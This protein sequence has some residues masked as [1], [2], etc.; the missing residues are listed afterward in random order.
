MRM[1]LKCSQVVADCVIL[2]L[3]EPARS[4]S[5]FPQAFSNRTSSE[6]T[7]HYVGSTMRHG[8]CS[9]L[10]PCSMRAQGILALRS[11][12]SLA[13]ACAQT[14]S[15]HLAWGN[16]A[17]AVAQACGHSKTACLD[18]T[19]ELP[20]IALIL[21]SQ[22]CHKKPPKKQPHARRLGGAGRRLQEGL[23]VKDGSCAQAPQ[24]SLSWSRAASGILSLMPQASAGPKHVL[25][26]LIPLQAVKQI[27]YSRHL[28]SAAAFEECAGAT[29]CL[30][31]H[32]ASMQKARAEQ[33]LALCGNCGTLAE[34]HH[35][36]EAEWHS[37]SN[38]MLQNNQ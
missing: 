11:C 27:P 35:L 13:H 17:L 20:L 4:P 25:L 30:A 2:E 14:G 29:C 36:L 32:R 34:K 9:R 16:L 22:Y 37:G 12:T 28:R 7:D 31:F 19:T 33:V 6:G 26:D 23:R 15:S 5:I 3:A 24:A 21:L 38:F 1:S 10:Y 8:C 18:F